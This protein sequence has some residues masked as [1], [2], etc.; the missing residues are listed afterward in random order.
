MLGSDHVTSLMKGGRSPRRESV[1]SPNRPTKRLNQV[2]SPASQL[3]GTN[4]LSVPYE[5]KEEYSAPASFATN[6]FDPIAFG[7][8]SNVNSINPF[9]ASGIPMTGI[10][11]TEEAPVGSAPA[12]LTTNFDPFAFGGVNPF[13]LAGM[14][15]A[16][17]PAAGIFKT[18]DAHVG[19]L[20][21]SHQYE[22]SNMKPPAVK[23]KLRTPND[24]VK[25]RLEEMKGLSF[26]EGMPMGPFDTKD[27]LI[28]EL[29]C[30][31]KDPKTYGGSFVIT[32]NSLNKATKFRGERQLLLCDKGGKSRAKDANPVDAQRQKTSKKLDCTWGVWIEHVDVGWM[33]TVPQERAITAAVAAGGNDC[34]VHNHPLLVTAAER[35]LNPSLREIPDDLADYANCLKKGGMGPSSIYRALVREC[36]EQGIDV[37]FNQD[38]IRNK[39]AVSAADRL[40]DCTNLIGHLKER[41]VLDPQAEYDIHLDDED[42]SLDRV[43][44]VLKGAHEVW[45]RS[46]G[47]VLLY[48][49]KHG[50][51]RYGLKLGCFTCVDENGRT[52]VLAG[53]FLLS[54]DEDSFSW[55]FQSFQNT[56]GSAPTVFFTDSDPAMALSIAKTWPEVIHLLCTFH[57]W[58]NFYLHI[59]PLFNGNAEAWKQVAKMFWRLCKASDSSGRAT[60]DQDFDALVKFVVDKSKVGKEKV[61]KQR[62]WLDELKAKKEK[63]AACYTWQHRTF[64][65]HSTQRAEAIHAAIA[66]FCSKTSTILEIVHDLEQM[67]D[68]Q[69]MKS[70]MDS[71]DHMFGAVTGATPVLPAFAEKVSKRLVGFAGHLTNVQATQLV[72]Y[73]CDFI[74]GPDVPA[75]DR[76]ALVRHFSDS[77]GRILD[78]NEFSRA[79]DHGISTADGPTT[80]VTTLTSCSCQY[81]KCW[82]LICRHIFRL[83]MDDPSSLEIAMVRTIPTA[84]V[85]IIAQNCFISNYFFYHIFSCYCKVDSG[86]ILVDIRRGIRG[87]PLREYYTRRAVQEF[88]FEETG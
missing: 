43:F 78:D 79:M 66:V 38:D 7:G 73:S 49:T 4:L 25:Q 11:K 23:G 76:R 26:P 33:V 88:L 8:V 3:R 71:L 58:K 32:K 75:A 40:L 50:T 45:D 59:H 60:F 27:V 74:D 2:P 18:E 42:G 67:A 70:E 64:G 20:S 46:K 16:G 36:R 31:A 85:C 57:I 5:P 81:P 54:E 22:T 1:L 82:G 53:S 21:S 37:T 15:T 51:N 55:A 86:S 80:H 14:P 9:P 56:F 44:F 69:C 6:T 83:I 68:E 29:Q 52:R 72:K 10:L 41:K 12:S 34:L 35:N 87:Y 65:I 39:Y 84:I 17:M 19:S 62:K 30:W 48:D 28:D 63:W 77:T 61:E 24:V 13:L 47:S